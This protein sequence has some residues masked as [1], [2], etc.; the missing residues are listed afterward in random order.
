M[1]ACPWT[2]ALQEIRRRTEDFIGRRFNGALLNF[3]RDGKDS[4][5][6]HR[7]NEKELGPQPVIAS[8]SLGGARIFELRRVSE[9]KEKISIVLTPGSLLLMLGE[10]NRY[11]E[12]QVPK[13][14]QVKESRI[15]ITFRIIDT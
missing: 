13:S 6:W 9:K 3:Y 12:H 1:H 2:S 10:T 7:D 14:S 8:V 5:G 4:M 15:N 11:W